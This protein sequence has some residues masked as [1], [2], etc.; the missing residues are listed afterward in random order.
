[1]SID[2][3]SIAPAL[4][5]SSAAVQSRWPGGDSFSGKWL[6]PRRL[7]RDA[8]LIIVLIGINKLGGP[9]NLLCFAVL[10]VM[11]ARNTEG[12]LK[13]LLLSSVINMAAGGP[14]VTFSTVGSALKFVLLG[15][16]AARIFINASRFNRRAFRYG[17]LKW[18]TGFALIAAALALVN[19]YYV[20]IV[21]LKLLS[22]TV[23]LAALLVAGQARSVNRV[24]LV[25]WLLAMSC[26]V[27]ALS[28]ASFALGGEMAHDTTMRGRVFS[29]FTGMFGHPQTMGVAAA[30]LTVLWVTFLALQRDA[31][32]KKIILP[33]V[34]ILVAMIYLSETRTGLLGAVLAVAVAYAVTVVRGKGLEIRRMKRFAQKG[35]TYLCLALPLLG[36]L[37]AAGV[38]D[39]MGAA[40]A[41]LAKNDAEDQQNPFNVIGAF[42]ESRGSLIEY[43]WNQFMEHPWTGVGFGVDTSEDWQS[44]ATL[45]S[46]STE[47]GFWPFAVLAEVGLIGAVPLLGLLITLGLFLLHRRQYVGL[48]M[49][50]VML[51]LNLA[52][53]SMFAFGG[54][55]MLTWTL[56]AYGM[57]LTGAPRAIARAP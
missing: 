38:T 57:L 53:M 24:R 33:L 26:V 25:R 20:E 41:F 27:V 4:P 5:C 17:P 47:R 22:F 16:A 54:L 2:T 13:A 6:A 21:L 14:F 56:I 15:V 31:L 39:I 34:V 30:M 36:A 29:G 49:L 28:L 50:V 18:L 42:E 19:D 52:E 37:E 23:G 11:A 45:L 51:V 9:G 43:N 8:L 7:A 44:K 12:A 32:A 55:G 35:L 1:M 40:Q 3:Q 10:L 48:A 46:A